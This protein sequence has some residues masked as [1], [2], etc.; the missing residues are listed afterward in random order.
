MK[1]G[2]LDPIKRYVESIDLSGTPREIVQQGD[3]GEPS[4]MFD[5]AKAQAQVVGAGLFS[6]SQGVDAAVREAISNSALLA[7]LV[8]NKRT[9]QAE[10]PLEWFKEYAGVLQNVGWVQQESGWSDY[11]TKGDALEVDQKIVE[12]MSA[13]LGPAPAALS[14]IT[15]TINALGAMDPSS[16]WIRIFSRESQQVRMGRFQIGLVERTVG[17]D[18]FVSL[19]ACLVEARTAMSQVLFFKFKNAQATFKANSTKVSIN[20]ASLM[21]LGP[22]ILKKVRAYQVDYLSNILDI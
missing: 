5:A 7:Q 4:G 1:N 6:F 18:V 14:I 12:V 8:A 20:R 9:S 11:T 3:R 10:A 22:T 17:D 21:D 19:L 15:T 13:V 16:S 2:S